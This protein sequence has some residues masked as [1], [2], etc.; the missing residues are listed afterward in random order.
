MTKLYA[1]KPSGH[2]E[3]SF[4]VVANSETEAIEAVTKHIEQN[5]TTNGT[6]NYEANG[7]GTDYYK[8]T[9]VEQGQVLENDN[10]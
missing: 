8:M 7:W 5:H 4:F 2:G 3:Y 9:V 10:C 6:L 1:F